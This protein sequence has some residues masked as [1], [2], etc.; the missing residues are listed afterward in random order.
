VVTKVHYYSV[1]LQ[2]VV[3]VAKTVVFAVVLVVVASAIEVQVVEE[4]Y[5][6]Q[7]LVLQVEG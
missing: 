1:E 3:S 2:V 4:E 6:M 5:F 7:M